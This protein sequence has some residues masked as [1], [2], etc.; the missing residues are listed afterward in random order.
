MKNNVYNMLPFF[1]SGGKMENI[2][3]IALFSTDNL[4]KDEK[5]TGNTGYLGGK[6][7]WGMR[8]KTVI[9]NI[10][11]KYYHEIWLVN[12]WWL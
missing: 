2:L 7:N 4:W 8:N 10:S 12:C 6:R 11:Y 5:E 1:L 9:S 3:V